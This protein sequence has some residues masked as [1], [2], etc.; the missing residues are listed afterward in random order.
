M[1][2]ELSPKGFTARPEM[3]GR[4]THISLVSKLGFD[5]EHKFPANTKLTKRFPRNIKPINPQ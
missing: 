4:D 3:V 1:P 5:P 2:V